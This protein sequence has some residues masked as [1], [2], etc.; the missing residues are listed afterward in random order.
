MCLL[1][2]RIPSCNSLLISFARWSCHQV[3]HNVPLQYF[4]LYDRQVVHKS[5]LL[6]TRQPEMVCNVCIITPRIISKWFAGKI[7]N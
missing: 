1:L 4:L 6:T 5:P 2:R 7:S 3:K